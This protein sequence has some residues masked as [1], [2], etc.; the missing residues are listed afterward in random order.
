MIT[1]KLLY[2]DFRSSISFALPKRDRE[3]NRS[4]SLAMHLQIKAKP[5]SLQYGHASFVSF[6]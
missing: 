3:H 1:E 2:Q 6:F 4:R 5:K